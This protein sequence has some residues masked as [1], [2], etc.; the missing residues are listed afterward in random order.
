MT[1]LSKYIKSVPTEIKRSQIHFADYNP[2][3]LSADERRA[4]KRGIKEFGLVGGLVVNRRTGFTVVSGH[5]RLSVMDELH[6]Y[7]DTD[8]VIRVD[9]IDVDEKQEKELNILLNNPNAQ[10]KW[11]YDALRELIPDINYKSAGL[12]DQDLSLIG[13]DYLLKTEEETDLAGALDGVMSELDEERE[14][15]KESR[16]LER[17]EAT[18][19]IKEVK[20]NVKESAEA[21]A[22]DMDAY[23]M[24]SFS[25]WNA[26]KRFC[27][28]YD[29]DPYDKFLKGED[30]EAR[31]DE[32]LTE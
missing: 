5:Q 19:H 31:L 4:I 9:V 8:Y 10:G 12:T 6:G 24:L 30:F 14:A 18:A 15:D 22:Q 13:V 26:K 21:N 1:E 7:P 28:K 17:A 29:L 25:D 27:D 32:L 11:D 16:K 23:V 20:A 3:K 2:R